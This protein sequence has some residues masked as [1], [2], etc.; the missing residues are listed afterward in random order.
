MTPWNPNAN[1]D[2]ECLYLSGAYLYVA[3][4]FSQVGGAQHIGIAKIVTTTGAV[5]AWDPEAGGAVNTVTIVGSNVVFA[6]RYISSLG[7]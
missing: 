3:G 4:L 1:N 7:G 6:G 2:V 5:M